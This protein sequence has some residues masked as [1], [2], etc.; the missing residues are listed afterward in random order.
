[1]EIEPFRIE[2]YDQLLF[3]WDRTGLHY[4]REDRDSREFLERQI[5]DDHVAIFILRHEGQI[6][7]SII[8]SSD[9]RK[10]WLNRLAID[11]EYRGRRLAT[12]LVEKAEEF[13]EEAGVHIIAALIEDENTPSMAAFRRCGYDAWS[14]IVYFRKCLNSK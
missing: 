6:I 13:L 12:R 3:L 14:R 7:G 1:M 4:D 10:G 2:E 9:G 5:F 8:A 11:P